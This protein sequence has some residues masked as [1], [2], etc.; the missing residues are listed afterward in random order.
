MSSGLGPQA[1]ARAEQGVKAA[2]VLSSRCHDIAAACAIAPIGTSVLAV[3]RADL[4]FDAAWTLP[5]SELAERMVTLADGG[6]SA[7]FKPGS[8][9][10]DVRVATARLLRLAETRYDRLCRWT[11]R[12]PRL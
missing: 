12:H 10:S 4:T 9:E 2:H 5:D 7:L 11:A 3:V 8:T 1:L 6:W